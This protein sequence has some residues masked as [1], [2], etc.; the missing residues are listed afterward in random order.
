MART[1]GAIKSLENGVT[2]DAP[3]RAS[4]KFMTAQENMQ[5]VRGS[6]LHRRQPLTIVQ[7]DMDDWLTTYP[8]GTVAVKD[9]T[10]YD[11]VYWVVIYSYAQLTT[12][13]VFLE[14]GTVLTPSLQDGASLSYLNGASIE[15]IDLSVNGDTVYITNKT[16][17]VA[18]SGIVRE[19]VTNSYVKILRAPLAGTELTISYTDTNGTAYEV[20]HTVG[21][22]AG[23]NGT[24]FLAAVLTG[25][26]SAQNPASITTTFKGSTVCLLRND[27]LYSDV[28]VEDDEGG[29][30]LEA[31][32]GSVPT[33]LNL[34]KYVSGSNII[35]IQPDSNSDRG[36]YYMQSVVEATTTSTT[37][38]AVDGLL[39]SEA[40]NA[41][42]WYF[43]GY[44]N[45]AG[46]VN[47]GDMDTIVIAGKTIDRLYY[48]RKWDN[49]VTEIHIMA[50]DDFDSPTDMFWIT[51]NV[52]ING[53]W[54]P[55]IDVSVTAQYISAGNYWFKGD[56]TGSLAE[57]EYQVIINQPAASSN[58]VDAVRWE[59]T[60]APNETY[61][62]DKNTM[63]HILSRKTTDPT[64][65]LGRVDW[66]AKNAG[67]NKT[68]K[69][70]AFVGTT[71]NETAIFQNRLITLTHDEIATSE[72]DN[73]FSF[74]KN[75]VTQSLASHPVRLYS[76]TA[77]SS[78]FN[79]AVEHNKD[80]LLF[81]KKKQFKLSGLIPL[82]P[83]TAGMPVTSSYINSAVTKPL[84][85]GKDVYFEFPYGKES[86]NVGISRYR[87]TDSDDNPDRATPI[88]EHIKKYIPAGIDVLLG[89]ANLG[90]VYAI[91]YTTGDVYVC[92][93]DSEDDATRRSEERLAWSHWSFTQLSGF[94][95]ILNATLVDG[96]LVFIILRDDITIDMVRVPMLEDPT[97]YFGW[98]LDQHVVTTSGND[99]AT[100]TLL[101]SYSYSSD[102]IVTVANPGSDRY[103]EPLEYTWDAGVLTLTDPTGAWEPI[104]YGYP[105]RSSMIPL[106]VYVKDAAG[107]WNSQTNLRI[108]K[109]LA[110]L[111]NSGEMYA[112]IISDYYDFP[113]QLWS[114]LIVNDILTTT[115]QVAN[116]TSVFHI[117]YRQ[118]TD[119]AQLELY[120]ESHLPMHIEGLDWLGSYTSR[121]RRF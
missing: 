92:N 35:T 110:S 46:Q 52:E 117:G 73:L 97:N 24:A 4:A 120:S 13:K 102:L 94:N 111:R 39:Q 23:E 26:I 33:P 72:T 118:R 76:T 2:T 112:R 51:L 63:P 42:D 28:A 121:G 49:S 113:D 116:N 67:D 27:K 1:S 29:E 74:Y 41:G 95:K 44:N 3:T 47:F 50:I 106:T 98:Y 54:Y 32:N 66:D 75:T 108:L 5:T 19:T 96:D 57:Y 78:D 103:G 36:T 55:A 56:V 37:S 59:E 7:L 99:G 65:E 69:D 40:Y 12:L 60:S 58:V 14:D 84:S 8:L 86:G 79:H 45:R 71:I 91:N 25:L 18:N 105:Y 10:L 30:I 21:S 107:M 22:I 38:P 114:G 85:L 9:F 62:L 16:Q 6:G 101:D 48:K 81:S 61:L 109:F 88:T 17:V 119:L 100:V 93:Y 34:P 11:T 53:V 43:W 70:P 31:I 68:N 77:G 90:N 20:T 115:D 87:S 15:D 89:D 64:F 82:T 80:L 83:Q 104:A